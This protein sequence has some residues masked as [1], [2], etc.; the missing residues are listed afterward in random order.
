[1]SNEILA[2]LDVMVAQQ[3]VKVLSLAR[4]LVP[5]IS[6]EDLRNPH[7]FPALRRSD[8]FNYEDG[9]LAGLLAARMAIAA[10]PQITI[11]PAKPIR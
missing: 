11:P 9:I 7:D 2:L 3:Q 10:V 4:T 8:V 1:V 6:A 5:D